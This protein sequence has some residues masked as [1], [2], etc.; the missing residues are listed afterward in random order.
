L[1]IRAS[2]VL[3]ARIANPRQRRFTGTDCKSAPAV[4]YSN[5][6]QIR[7]SGGLQARIANPRQRRFTATDYKSAPAK[8][9]DSYFF[10]FFT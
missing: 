8:V 3:Q 1:Q 10:I 2:G 6:L 7:A 9:D 4:F 5:G